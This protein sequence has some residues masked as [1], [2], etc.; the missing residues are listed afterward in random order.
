MKK[1]LIVA[2]V[3]L[4]FV[5]CKHT[6]ASKCSVCPAIAV[7]AP[8][9]GVRI[10]DKTTGADLF[11]SPGSP[12]QLSDLKVTG[13]ADGNDLIVNV[14][15]TDKANRFIRIIVSPQTFKLKL[16]DLAA[17]NI[18]VTMK[19]D[20]PKCCSIPKIHEVD[21]NNTVVCSACGLR[22]IVIIKK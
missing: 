2:L 5:S 17:D 1:L 19:L 18:R 8:I 3:L 12:Y 10:V 20:S 6:E 21:L 7:V 16:G 13:S 15:S 4:A 14:D 11:L 22:P 9:I